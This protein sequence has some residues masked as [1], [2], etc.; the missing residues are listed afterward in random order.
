MD[1]LIPH[2][3][4]TDHWRTIMA[5]VWLPVHRFGAGGDAKMCAVKLKISVL[6]CFST[7]HSLCFSNSKPVFRIRNDSG[8]ALAIPNNEWG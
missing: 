8:I 5:P 3:P 4:K 6:A 7:W 2:G 1:T